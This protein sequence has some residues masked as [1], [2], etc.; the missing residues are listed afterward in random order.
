LSDDIPRAGHDPYAPFRVSAYRRYAV[1]GIVTRLGTRMQS[2]AVGWDVYQRTGE[3]LALG[4]V[5]LVQVI[6]AILLALP[7]GWL[8]DSFD[9]RKVVL[10]SL[11]GMTLT[12]AGLALQAV[13]EADVWVVYTLLTLDAVVGTLGRPARSSLVPRLVPREVFPSAVAWNN[14]M[15]QLSGVIGPALGGFVIA[16]SIP[17]AYAL[18]AI[19]SLLFAALLT[20]IPEAAGVA[21]N[22]GGHATL[23]TLFDGVHYLR[24]TRVLLAIISLDMFAVLLGGAVFLLP[25][26][27][28]DILA[29]GAEGLGYLHAAPAVGA[30]LMALLLAHLPPMAKAGRALLLSVAGFGVATI[31]FG[32]STN[33]YLSLAVLFLT[34]AFDQVSMVVRHTMVQLT[35]PDAMRGRVSAVNGVFVSASNELGGFESGLVAHWFGPIVAVVSGGI[36]TLLVVAATTWA[37]PQLRRFGSLGQIHTRQ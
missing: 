34:G 2:V 28:E 17:A 32:L 23:S 1:G 4:L 9:R 10:L 29:V 5:G 27:A 13:L 11:L 25:V 19:S 36:G 35:T 24:R 22:G 15:F 8:A 14:S 3:P 37:A 33:L 18:A 26:F 12:S 21:D 20:R 30:L 31:I 6:P 16:A 7:A